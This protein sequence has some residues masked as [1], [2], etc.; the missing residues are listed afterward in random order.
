MLVVCLY[1]TS[2]KYCACPSLMMITMLS[3][4]SSAGLPRMAVGVAKMRV[5]APRVKFPMLEFL[6]AQLHPEGE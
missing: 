2:L 6:S 5:S 3:C 4:L 1:E